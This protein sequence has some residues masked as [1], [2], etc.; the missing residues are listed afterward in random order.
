MINNDERIAII[1][2]HLE[3]G[4]EIPCFDGVII[5]ESVI[6]K[7]KAEVQNKVDSEITART[8]SDKVFK[9]ADFFM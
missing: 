9:D 2:K 6:N 7:M 1:N 4:V 8:Y 5:E 3:K